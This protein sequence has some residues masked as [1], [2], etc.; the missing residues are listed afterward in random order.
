VLAALTVAAALGWR[1]RAWRASLLVV[2]AGS[3]GLVW[4]L[5]ALF[6][7]SWILQPAPPLEVCALAAAPVFVVASIPIGWHGAARR[8]RVL[9]VPAVVL[10]TLASAALINRYYA[11]FPTLDAVFSRH[12]AHE[13]SFRDLRR[14]GYLEHRGDAVPAVASSQLPAGSRPP[15]APG[16]T[17]VGRVLHVSI[18]G[19]VSRFRAR[20][21]WIYLPPIWF[22]AERPRLPVVLL[23]N[24][25]PGSPGDWIR[26]VQIQHWADAYAAAHG[27]W[28]P[29]L[30][31]AD[32]NGSFTGDTECVDHAGALVDTYL[33]VDVRSYVITTFDAFADARHWAVEGFSEGGTC[34][35]TLALR[36]PTL[37]RSFVDIAGEARPSI[38]SSS[39]TLHEL[40]GGSRVLQADYDPKVLLRAGNGSGMGAWFE[41]GTSDTSAG[42]ATRELSALAATSGV[43]VELRQLRGV[44]NF[45]VFRA[46]FGDSFPWLCDRLRSG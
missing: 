8:H 35:A 38:G 12:P 39:E 46:G 33:S 31:A 41:V 4:L 3:F 18:P 28:S 20:P 42:P 23:L 22:S 40:F 27:G 2:A 14:H 26:Q 16:T 7:G 30:V 29:I 34:A 6:G 44:H 5:D 45:H 10:C 36:H 13:I 24:G 21:A 15:S 43:A 19:T 17:Q 11:Y 25:T 37:F 32:E 9:L 1:D